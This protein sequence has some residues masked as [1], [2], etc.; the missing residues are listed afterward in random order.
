M[1]RKLSRRAAWLLIARAFDARAHG[2]PSVR[3]GPKG[4]VGPRSL[5]SRVAD[6]GLCSATAVLRR[7]GLI[8]V[9]DEFAMDRKAK[10]CAGKRDGGGHWYSGGHW[11][12][13][14][15]ASAG[16]RAVFATLMALVPEPVR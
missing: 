9:D 14:D 13:D 7:E 2:L 16:D 8:S 10:W 3:V 11:W 4:V 1:P 15:T 5:V 6:N 12:P